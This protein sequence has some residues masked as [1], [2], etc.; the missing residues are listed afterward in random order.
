MGHVVDAL[1]FTFPAYPYVV[2]MCGLSVCPQ[3][4]VGGSTGGGAV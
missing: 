3:H 2:E 4:T 1:T